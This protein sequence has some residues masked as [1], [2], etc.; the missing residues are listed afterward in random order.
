MMLLSSIK[1]IKI[2]IT[3]GMSNIHLKVIVEKN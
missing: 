2:L 1:E 3:K